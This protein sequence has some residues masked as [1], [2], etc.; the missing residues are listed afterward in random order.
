MD[1]LGLEHTRQHAGAVRRRSA[2]RA[3][4][5]GKVVKDGNV[6]PSDLHAPQRDRHAP[7][8]LRCGSATPV[9]QHARA[10]Q[11]RDRRQRRRPA[12]RHRAV[13]GGLVLVDKVPQGHKV[14]LVDIAA[15]DAVRRYDVTHR[16]RAARHPG[17]QLGARAPARD[18]RGARA[19][20]PADRH[21]ARRRRCRRSRATPSRATATPTARSARATCS[22]SRPP[23]S[24]WPA[25]SSSRCSASSSEL[26]PQY[27]NVDDVVGLEHSYGCGVAIDA[28]DAVI[29]I[30]TLRNI[31]LN[32]NFGGEVMV[33]SLGCEKLQPERLLPPGSFAIATSATRSRRQLDVV[34]LQD[35]AHVGFTSMIDS[36]LRQADVHLERLNARRRETV[37]ASE[38]VVGVQCGGSDAFSRRH[39]QPGGR[40]LHRPAGARRRHRDVQ[41]DHRGARRHRPAHRA[42][43]DARGGRRR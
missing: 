26:L 7:R 17:R 20:R 43:R 15:G 13:A 24:A 39:R 10:R 28:P 12:G 19:R 5:V 37:P 25:W 40:L 27:P 29:P 36:I 3:G 9:H 22:P 38:L 32:P 21:R 42:R 1:G 33:V 6:K 18:A 16:P 35:E 34:C 8:T 4:E 23:C 31:S 11:R 14:A 30:R 2:A 41:R